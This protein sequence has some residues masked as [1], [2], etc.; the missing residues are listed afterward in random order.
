MKA[1]DSTLGATP[2]KHRLHRPRESGAALVVALILMVV[3]SLM[4]ISSMNTASLDLIMTGNEQY[5]SRSFVAAEA[6]IESAVQFGTLDSGADSS[7]GST[8]VGSGSDRFSYV[9]TRPN[10]GVPESGPTSST[11]N[12]G[13]GYSR[14]TFRITSTGTSERG[15]T[16]A[17]VQELY[18][19]TP[20]SNDKT[21]NEECGSAAHDLYSTSSGC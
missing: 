1:S 19:V 6:G 14:I 11:M 18:K 10:N 8:A 15:S 3:L 20:S 7:Q 16:S 4:V 13:S 2:G 21:A 5:R 9:I 12:S 17:H